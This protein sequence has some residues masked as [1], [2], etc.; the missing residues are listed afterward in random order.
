MKSFK[1]IGLGAPL[2]LI[3]AALAAPTPVLATHTTNLAGRPINGDALAPGASCHGLVYGMV[4]NRPVLFTADHCHGGQGNVVSGIGGERIG[5]WGPRN[6]AGS[7]AADLAFIW[8]DNGKWP[9]NRNRVYRGEVAGNNWWTMTAQPYAV[10]GIDCGTAQAMSGIY[11]NWQSSDTS[12]TPYRTGVMQYWASWS[13]T[14]CNI[15]ISL[16]YHGEGT[17]D[18][19]SPFIHAS[20]TNT[21]FGI[22]TYQTGNLWVALTRTGF[23]ALNGYYQ[24]VGTHTGVRICT[25]STAGAC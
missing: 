18:S 23:V 17:L 3:L 4:D 22:A 19:G 21:I 1:R 14:Y 16:Q 11:H 5:T 7:G 2:A 20:H 15:V 8:L 12:T 9:A 24:S 25:S 6:V 13:P 10:S